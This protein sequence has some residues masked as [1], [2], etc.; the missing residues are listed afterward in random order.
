MSRTI[1]VKTRFYRAGSPESAGYGYEW[2]EGAFN[3]SAML[4]IDVYGLGLNLHPDDP[5]SHNEKSQPPEQ[6]DVVLNAVSPALEAAR[7][8]GLTVIFL[9][10]SA[11]RIALPLSEF[12]QLLRRQLGF[13]IE[14]DFAENTVD[15]REYHTGE[16]DVLTLSNLLAPREGEY[17]IRKHVYS[18]FVGTRLDLLLRHLDIKTL[19]TMGFYADACLFATITDAL[20]RNYKVILLRDATL[21]T[22]V[23]NGMLHPSPTEG[24]VRLMEALYCVSITSREFIAALDSNPVGGKNPI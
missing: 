4:V 7:A 6:R 24:I 8:A 1:A 9:N 22:S 5:V 10:N 14:E 23:L 11:P 17:F 15:P 3:R 13:A 19:F 2:V 21:A 12:G 16:S 20:W 18:G